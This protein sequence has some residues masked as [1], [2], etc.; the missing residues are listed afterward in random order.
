MTIEERVYRTVSRLAVVEHVLVLE[1]VA[2]AG[3]VPTMNAVALH[4]GLRELI[5]EAFY[6][7]KP[8]EDAPVEISGWEPTD[9]PNE[10]GEGA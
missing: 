7:L 9:E 6:E 1:M 4:T 3:D 8:I 10:K 2:G 5:D